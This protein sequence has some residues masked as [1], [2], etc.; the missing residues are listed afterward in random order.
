MGRVDLSNITEDDLPSK[1]S[2]YLDS[3]LGERVT[4]RVPILKE[5]W[6]I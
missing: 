2:I 5:R 4:N 1:D 3:T 6:S